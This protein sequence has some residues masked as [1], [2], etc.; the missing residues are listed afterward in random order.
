MKNARPTGVRLF[1]AGFTLRLPADTP[2]DLQLLAEHV[3]ALLRRHGAVRLSSG[4]R[5]WWLTLTAS[6]RSG[7]CTRCLRPLD[8]AVRFG[9]EAVA[10]VACA[11][12]SVISSHLQS[13]RSAA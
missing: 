1:A 11:S 10:C 3:S 12:R 2:Y 8:P 4:R 7:H 5:A 13:E 6:A 9:G